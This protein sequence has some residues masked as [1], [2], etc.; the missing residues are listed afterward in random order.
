LSVGLDCVLGFTVDFLTVGW[1]IRC[2]LGSEPTVHSDD[3][4]TEIQPRLSTEQTSDH[5]HENEVELAATIRWSNNSFL[6]PLQL[7]AQLSGFPNLHMLYNS[8]CCLPVSSA[9]AERALSK[10]KIIKNHLRTSMSDET[11]SLLLVLA[12]EKDLM[13]QLSADEIIVNL[14]KSSESLKWYLLF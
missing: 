3:C 10:L 11:L 2:T 7:S 6:K 5:S 14:V 13:A 1:F 9:S 4:T 12:A 8:F